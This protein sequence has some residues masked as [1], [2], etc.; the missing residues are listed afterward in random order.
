MSYQTRLVGILPDF[1]PG[2]DCLNLTVPTCVDLG[3]G[4]NWRSNYNGTTG[5]VFGVNRSDL[6]ADGNGTGGVTITE[7][8]DTTNYQ[9]NGIVVALVNGAPIGQQDTSPPT[10]TAAAT[11]S[12]L[13]PPRQW[14]VPVTVS[15]TITDADSGVNAKTAAYAVIDEYGEVQPKGAVTLGTKGDYSFTVQL[16]ASRK[17]NDKDGRKYTITVNAEDNVGNKGSSSASVIVPHDQRR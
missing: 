15:G 9:Y 5:G 16:P 2:S 14:M 13:W 1:I 17:G 10:I 7:V 3:L 8:F 6:P 12:S 4:F 11:P